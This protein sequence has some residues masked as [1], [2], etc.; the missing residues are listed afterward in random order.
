MVFFQRQLQHEQLLLMNISLLQRLLIHLVPSSPPKIFS[1]VP[2]LDRVLTDDEFDNLLRRIERKDNVVTDF[3][4]L[5]NREDIQSILL[6]ESRTRNK[7]NDHERLTE[8]S[9]E[10]EEDTNVEVEYND[11]SEDDDL[12]EEERILLKE[13]NI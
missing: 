1:K 7:V 3:E 13:S 2:P 12:T 10:K 6:C 11:A 4:K 9:M 5:I 8:D